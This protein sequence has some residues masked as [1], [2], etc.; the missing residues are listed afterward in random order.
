MEY[1]INL[2][3]KEKAIFEKLLNDWDVNQET[4]ARKERDEKLNQINK[5]LCILKNKHLCETI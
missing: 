4:E 3:E 2:L 5:S 1:V